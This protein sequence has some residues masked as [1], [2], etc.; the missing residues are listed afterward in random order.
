MDYFSKL[1]RLCSRAKRIAGV[2][3]SYRA[4]IPKMSATEPA[5]QG[6]FSRIP[7]SSIPIN[8]HPSANKALYNE[9]AASYDA[10]LTDPS[11]GYVGP[12]E[13]AKAI[14]EAG[15]FTSSPNDPALVL[16]AGCG[17]GLSGIAVQLQL[18]KETV[19]DG[20]DISEGMLAVAAKTG[21]YRNLTPTDLSQPFANIASDTYNVV[22]CVGTL[23][24]G[25]VPPSPALEEFARVCKPQ[26]LVVATV[27]ESVWSSGGYEAEVQR[28]ANEGLVEI[29]GTGLRPYRQGQGV[30][31]VMLVMR[32]R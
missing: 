16:D 8:E 25:H 21:V 26:G 13:A 32:R 4:S 1:T 9:W 24:A 12:L 17:T 31:A 19:I 28:L 20:I 15:S 18:G 23:T 7:G 3:Y 11:Q 6:F 22:V 14:S 30:E 5:G 29:V 10:D 27:K 2:K